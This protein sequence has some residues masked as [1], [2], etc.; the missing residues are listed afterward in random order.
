MFSQLCSAD[1]ENPKSY[2]VQTF[3]T[4]KNIFL[5]A[6]MDAPVGI[7]VVAEFFISPLV[8]IVTVVTIYSRRSSCSSYMVF[9]L[10]VYVV[11][12]FLAQIMFVFLLFLGMVMYA[13]EVATKGKEKLP[14]GVDDSMA[15]SHEV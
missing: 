13:N 10:E 6:T 12:N 2:H 5:M 15:F 9:S 1:H 3:S 8:A 4:W 7:Y 14:A 11:V